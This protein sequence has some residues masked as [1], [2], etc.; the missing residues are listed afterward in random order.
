MHWMPRV[1]RLLARRPWIYWLTVGVLALGCA[2][3]L[4][5]AARDLD[6]A[7]A[8]WGETARVVVSTRSIGPGEPLEGAISA[9]ELPRAIVPASALRRLSPGA[10][11]TQ[12]VAPGEVIVAI[13]VAPSTGPLALLPDGW[14]AVTIDGSGAQSAALFEVGHAAAVLGSGQILARDAIILDVSAAGVAVG[15]PADAA[16]AV[17]DAAVQ[18]SAIVAMVSVSATRPR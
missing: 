13:D 8:S 18:H 1:R 10:T 15:V 6:H 16:A 2:A 4:A 5:G 17:A 12:H 7:R 3:V 11:A 14:M 9:R